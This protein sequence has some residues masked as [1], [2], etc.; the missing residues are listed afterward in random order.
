MCCKVEQKKYQCLRGKSGSRER[1]RVHARIS[2]C[3]K[4]H[5]STLLGETYWMPCHAWSQF[6]PQSTSALLL[7]L[8]IFKLGR[9]GRIFTR[10]QRWTTRKFSTYNVHTQFALPQ[11]TLPMATPAE[12]SPFYLLLNEFWEI[13]ITKSAVAFFYFFHWPCEKMCVIYNTV[14]LLY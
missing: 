2:S 13:Q 14:W 4:K 9:K 12:N 8:L 7:V 1:V 6:P 5:G 11:H 10:H 3:T